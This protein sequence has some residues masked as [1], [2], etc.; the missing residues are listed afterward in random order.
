MAQTHWKK[1]TN[2]NYLGEYAFE[3]GRDLIGTIKSIQNEMVTGDGGRKEECTVCHFVERELK[4]MV[5]NKTNMKTIQKL[6]G[7]PYIEEWSGHKIAI[8]V[9]PK[10]K[11]GREIVGGLRIRPTIP[12]ISAP[13]VK[14]VSCGKDIVPSNGM[15]SVQL[16]DYT[17]VKYG[18]PLCAKCAT[19]KAQE[20]KNNAE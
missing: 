8:Y 17:K 9:D 3:K 12:N 13:V 7:T 2:P 11:F 15:T 19:I 1:L 6:T 14:C 5:L 18:Q 4:P 10:V 20:A 16:A